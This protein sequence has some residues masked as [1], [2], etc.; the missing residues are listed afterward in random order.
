[1][2]SAVGE[3]VFVDFFFFFSVTPN[4]FAVDGRSS[5]DMVFVDARQ[6]KQEIF[7]NFCKVDSV[8]CLNIKIFL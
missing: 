5:A 4:R 6:V 1:M 3:F 7:F 8:L 2:L